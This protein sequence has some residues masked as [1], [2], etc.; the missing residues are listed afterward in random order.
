MTKPA[1]PGKK[2]E[3]KKAGRKGREKALGEA[4]QRILNELTND[5]RT[6]RREAQAAEMEA[7]LLGKDAQTL[8]S[9]L[10]KQDSALCKAIPVNVLRMSHQG[11]QYLDI[12][13]A[14]QP[15]LKDIPIGGSTEQNQV[16]NSKE[17]EPGEALQ[18]SKAPDVESVLPTLGLGE[19]DGQLADLVKEVLASGD[20]CRLARDG[21]G[22]TDIMGMFSAVTDIVNRK[23][24]EGSLDLAALDRQAQA[25]LGRMQQDHP[26]LQDALGSPDVATLL[27]FAG[28]MR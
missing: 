14:L 13:A 23:A 15:S 11:K 26:E 6:S 16:Q 28:S 12:L 9:E 5:L 4:V 7:A 8:M 18:I 3:D 24:S 21:P 19:E 1:N 17:D 27:S 22:S 25:M 2:R 20:M 10:L